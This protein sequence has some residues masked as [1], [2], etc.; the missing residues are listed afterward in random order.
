VDV[1]VR[2]RPSVGDPSSRHRLTKSEATAWAAAVRP[3]LPFKHSP[4]VVEP[5]M[6]RLECGA[7]DRARNATAQLCGG[8]YMHVGARCRPARLDMKGQ[9]HVSSA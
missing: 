2:V 4:A 8:I 5:P 1:A 9:S 6:E 3:S 7:V